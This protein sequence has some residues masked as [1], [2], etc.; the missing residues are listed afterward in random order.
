MC[1]DPTDF[2]EWRNKPAGMRGYPALSPTSDRV[3]TA[4]HSELHD[5]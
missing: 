1:D 5:A 3:V 2:R 4:M